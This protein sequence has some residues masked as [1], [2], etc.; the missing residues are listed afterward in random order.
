M[1]AMDS[2]RL[3]WYV[4]SG[5]L[6]STKHLLLLADYLRNRHSN[7]P[8]WSNPRGVSRTGVTRIEECGFVI[9]LDSESLL[10][11]SMMVDLSLI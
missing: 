4:V 9:S 6:L 11:L 10:G 3:Q 7:E 1:D 8:G 5:Y 2:A